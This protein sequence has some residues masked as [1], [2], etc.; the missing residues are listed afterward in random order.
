MV[1]NKEFEGSNDM[2]E[3]AQGCFANKNILSFLGIKQH[4]VGLGLL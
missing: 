4:R 2:N 1:K 3:T